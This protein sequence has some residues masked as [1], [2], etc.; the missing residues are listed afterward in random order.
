MNNILTGSRNK[1]YYEQSHISTITG[2]SVFVFL[3]LL[4]SNLI[5]LKKYIYGGSEIVIA[6]SVLLPLAFFIFTAFSKSSTIHVSVVEFLWIFSLF[7]IIY[8]NVDFKHGEMGILIHYMI[9]V[10]LL[11]F[12]KYSVS[13]MSAYSKL[14]VG[15]SILHTSCSILFFIIPGFYEQYIVKLFD[16]S[17][18]SQLVSWYRDGYATGLA[19]HYSQN[20]IYLAIATGVSFCKLINSRRKSV[21]LIFF[22]SCLAALLMSGK[23]GPLV[24]SILAIIITYY[25]FTSNKPLNRMFKL[26]F[27][28]SI[29]VIAFF[30]ILNYVPALSGTLDRFTY[31]GD[32]TGGRIELYQY[33]W[34]WFKE[35]PFTGIGWGGYPY[36]IN[37]TYIG[38]IYGQ[39]ANMY[40]HNV[41]LQLLCE[42][43]IPGFIYFLCCFGV[44]L[45]KTVK[46]LTDSRKGRLE[47]PQSYT[48]YLTISLFIQMFFIQ[49]C[50]SGN[51]LYDYPVLYPYLLS[52]AIPITIDFIMKRRGNIH[53]RN[54]DVY[55]YN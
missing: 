28:L 7:F 50:M 41:Y 43:G 35:A 26:A 29:F 36:K 6:A 3:L 1:V 34:Q 45:Y 32:I 11:V 23:R 4:Y 5:S 2:S 55:Q 31:D 42:V 46:L 49:Y 52:C 22:V 12:C 48:Y 27:L 13:W 51:A 53:D 47:C 8:K 38:L 19:T 21:N 9:L 40:V 18:Y 54:T 16:T 44:T 37:Y 15:F 24:F 25:V 33:A 39:T 17:Y 30:V 14:M 20:G 10:L